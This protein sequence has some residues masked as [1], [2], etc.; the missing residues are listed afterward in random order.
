MKRERYNPNDFSRFRSRNICSNYA[1]I[2]QT[3][4]RRTKVK[5]ES[6]VDIQC[7]KVVRFLTELKVWLVV[8]AT[9]MFFSMRACV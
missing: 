8:N 5:K 2:H 4:Q 7:V 9:A 3:E 1:F 6:K